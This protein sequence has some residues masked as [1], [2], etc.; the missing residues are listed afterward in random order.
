MRYLALTQFDRAEMLKTIGVS[1]VDELFDAVPA[2]F[3]L[4][5]PIGY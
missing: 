2:E 3:L 5:K 4:K 1:S